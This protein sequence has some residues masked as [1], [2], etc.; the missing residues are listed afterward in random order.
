MGLGYSMNSYNHNLLVIPSNETNP[1]TTFRTITSDDGIDGS[2][3]VT[4][5]IEM[6]LQFRWRTSNPESH[7]FWRI[8]AGVRLGYMH[9]FK[10]SFDN[11]EGIQFKSK[12]PD[13]LDRLRTGATLTFGWNTFNFH[14]YYSLNSFFDKSVQIENQAGGFSA[15]KLGLMFYIL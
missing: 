1:K 9:Y 14:M 6:P 7:K 15:I 8:Y 10:S 13:G 11:S 12:K 2:R 3:F 4:H 5:L